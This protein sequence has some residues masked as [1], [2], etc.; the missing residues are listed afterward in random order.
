M[1]IHYKCPNCGND[2][3]YDADSSRLYC[4]FCGR[5]DL[6]EDFPEENIN[7]EFSDEVLEYHCDNCGANLITEEETIATN[8][9]FCGAAMVIGDRISGD[10]APSKLIP[11]SI[12][13]DR[14]Q[15][16]NR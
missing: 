12:S 3:K 5:E 6:V 9:S 4:E 16:A 11:F 8:C 7:R 15:K 2:M 13:K 1:I 14:A 10:M